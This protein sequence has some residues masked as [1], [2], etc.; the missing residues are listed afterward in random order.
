MSGVFSDPRVIFDGPE[1]CNRIKAMTDAEI[2]ESRNRATRAA[3]KAG[4]GQA[5][6]AW[7]TLKAGPIAP[8]TER[9]QE[10]I[11]ALKKAGADKV[12]I[13]KRHGAKLK[14]ETTA[15]S[16]PKSKPKA[17]ASVQPAAPA[18]QQ[19][20]QAMAPTVQP[21]ESGVKTKTTKKAESKKT[22]GVK[23][24]TM[25]KAEAKTTGVRP[26]S[27]LEIIVGLLKRKEGCTAKQIL[28]AVQWPAVSVPQMARS[29]GLTLKKEKVDGV[30]VYRAA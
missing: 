28:D 9:D 10:V 22:A 26:G 1:A 27:K 21:Q 18:A 12:S 19:E 14:S 6:R 4:R 16:P 5:T 30:T 20:V 11:R 29:A 23:A 2:E 8:L 15:K 13:V 25:V 7:G 3:G 24:R 17:S